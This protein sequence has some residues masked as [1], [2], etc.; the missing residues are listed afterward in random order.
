M[1]G[2]ESLGRLLV[3]LGVCALLLGILFI[4][5]PKAPYP[6]RLPGDIFLHKGNFTL[7]FPLVTMVLASVGLTI[8]LNLVLRIFRG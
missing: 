6:G 8:V 1:T 4:L 2:L 7:Y 5:A 3:L